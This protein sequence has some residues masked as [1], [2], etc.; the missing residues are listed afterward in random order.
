MI[1]VK[2]DLGVDDITPAAIISTHM[3][4]KKKKTFYVKKYIYITFYDQFI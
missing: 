3:Y 1:N 4:K 2:K